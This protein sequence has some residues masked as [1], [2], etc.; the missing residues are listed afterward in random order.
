MT[1]PASLSAINYKIRQSNGRF[2]QRHLICNTSELE[3]HL[4][5]LQ[6]DPGVKDIKSFQ[7]I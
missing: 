6:Q 4:E 7:N 3:S 5:R 1:Q 2:A